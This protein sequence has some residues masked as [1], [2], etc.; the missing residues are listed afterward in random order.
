MLLMLSNPEQILTLTATITN[1]VGN[2]RNG[3]SVSHFD[4]KA[5]KWLAEFA[6]DCANSVARMI[7]PFITE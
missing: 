5:E 6:R 1:A 7:L 2:A 3:Y 4:G